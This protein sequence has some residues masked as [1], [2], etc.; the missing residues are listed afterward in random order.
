MAAEAGSNHS[1]ER[2]SSVPRVFTAGPHVLRLVAIVRLPFPKGLVRTCQELLD[3]GLPA[4]EVTLNTP[5]ALEAIAALG[6]VG[7]G[8]VRTVQDAVRAQ[9]A[10][11]SFLVT[12]TVRPEVLAAASVP[13]VC[14]ALTPTEIDLAW[15]SGAAYVKLFPA[16]A[17]GPRYVREVLAPMPEIPLIPTGGITLESVP[18]Y[19][20]AGAAG[21]GVG[22][23][24]VSPSI[25]DAE[26]WTELRRRARLFLGAW[27]G[28]DG[29]S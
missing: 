18:E 11:A 23:A 5:G 20:A 8:S 1:V 17:V 13:V 28:P 15:S 12:P 10:G 6:S 2:A 9:E 22:S 14:G 7:A 26:D 29:R 16:S 21:V 3:A 19:A 4:V 24:L 27:P 25:V